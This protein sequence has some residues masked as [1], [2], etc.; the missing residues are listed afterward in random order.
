[1]SLENTCFSNN[2]N[3]SSNNL[4]FFGFFLK[5]LKVGSNPRREDFRKYGQVYIGEKYGKQMS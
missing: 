4:E 5:K 2:N 3:I 1:M